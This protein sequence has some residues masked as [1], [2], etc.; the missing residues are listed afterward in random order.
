MSHLARHACWSLVVVISL[1]AGCKRESSPREDQVAGTSAK[2][3]ANAPAARSVARASGSADIA[4]EKIM[5]AAERGL[6]YLVKKADQMESGRAAQVAKLDGQVA[7]I[8]KLLAAGK[9]DE[10]EVLLVDIHWIPVEA[11]RHEQEFIR[12]YDEKRAALEKFLDE[13]KGAKPA[14]P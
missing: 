2:P 5:E 1:A 4:P 14:A 11:A 8:Q 7:R 6:K 13:K 9:Y 10:A 12:T 3:A